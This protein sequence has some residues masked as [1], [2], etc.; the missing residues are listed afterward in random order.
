MHCQYRLV[1]LHSIAKSLPSTIVRAI[2]TD[3]T[4]VYE[5]DEPLL[6]DDRVHGQFDHS[7]VSTGALPQSDSTSPSNDNLPV[8]RKDS[9]SPELA[10]EVND[11]SSTSRDSPSMRAREV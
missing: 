11:S 4:E 3:D 6:P 5:P 10:D 9:P 2:A 7:E 8:K 1:V